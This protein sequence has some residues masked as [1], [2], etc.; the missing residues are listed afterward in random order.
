MDVRHPEQGAVLEEREVSQSPACRHYW[1]IDSPDGPVSKGLCQHC[2]EVREFK[3][4]LD[5]SYWDNVTLDQ[6]STG[7]LYPTSIAL[8]G[9]A[10]P[11]DDN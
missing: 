11:D 6:V 1:I 7:S 8:L 9:S 5:G 10:E 2:S 3:N 4:S